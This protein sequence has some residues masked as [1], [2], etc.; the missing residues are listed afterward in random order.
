MS[1]TARLLICERCD[2][3]APLGGNMEARI[4]ALV[5]GGWHYDERGVNYCPACWKAHRARKPL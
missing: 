1:S 4:R 2:A 5:A 3:R